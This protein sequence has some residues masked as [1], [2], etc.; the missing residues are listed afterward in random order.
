LNYGRWLPFVE[1]YK[2][3]MNAVAH[4]QDLFAVA[5]GLHYLDEF[6]WME[7]NT[8]IEPN[9]IFNN[10]NDYLPAHFFNSN[11]TIFVMV[12]ENE[13]YIERLEIKTTSNLLIPTISISHNITSF[14]N[15]PQKLSE[16]LNSKF[17]FGALDSAHER[18]KNLLKQILQPSVSKLIKLA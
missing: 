8:P 14:Q 7:K 13:D 12:T 17:F 1:D 2:E 3:N 11:N 4:Q 15:N 5:F 9:L 16:L 6:Y 10:T 18:N